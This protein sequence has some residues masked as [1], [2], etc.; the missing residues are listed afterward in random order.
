MK[1]R[2]MQG[3]YR[4]LAVTVMGAAC[5]TTAASAATPNPGVSDAR[6]SAWYGCWRPEALDGATAP[7]HLVCVLPG[8]GAGVSIA[9]IADGKIVSEQIVVADG[10][11]RATDD[12][13]CKGFESAS[14]SKDGRRVFLT[15]ELNCG[16]DIQRKSTGILALVSTGSYVD[17]QSVDV[18]GEKASRTVRYIAVDETETPAI[19]RDRLPD[20]PLATESARV[21]AA[22]PLDFED[23]VEA[24]RVVGSDAV[25]GVLVARRAGFALNGDRLLDLEKA[26]V[27]PST[28]DVMVALS[29]PK[30]FEVAEEAP[31]ASRTG[32]V[33]GGDNGSF[34]RAYGSSCYNDYAFDR[35]PRYSYEP[36]GSRYSRCGNSS[37]Y[38][39]YGYD[40]YGWGYGT[41]PV[42]IVSGGS[43]A[44]EVNG[45]AVKGKGYTR[46]G[47]ATGTA[48]PKAAP[49]TTTTTRASGATS[50]GT[51]VKS[52]AGASGGSSSSG[53]TGRTAKPKTGGGGL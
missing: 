29:Y 32:N 4:I 31:R 44:D 53:S 18:G 9:T 8:S 11:P 21:R 51:A 39:P 10:S 42:I 6:W 13:G 5:V 37:F 15:S 16:S 49:T 1:M 3:V 52:G 25:N 38:S 14:W 36:Y 43:K 35:S 28:V 48:R 34:G 41:S 2:T 33:W 7:A 46:R 30:H 24:T 50:S 45:V 40:S 12:G 27:K 26:G 47:E 22:S 20:E 23:V 17:V 19:V